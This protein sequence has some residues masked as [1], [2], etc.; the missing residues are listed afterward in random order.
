MPTLLLVRHAIAEPRGAVW[1]DDT[2]RPLTSK[3]IERMHDV[4][5]RLQVLKETADLVLSSPLVRA[6]QTAGIFREVWTPA[7][8]VVLVDA[9]APGG[10]P[11]Q[12]AAALR[13]A[14]GHARVAVVGHEP[15]LGEWAAWLTGARAPLPFKKGGVARIDVPAWPPSR[16]GQL[17]WLATPKMLRGG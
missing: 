9:F 3:G 14:A 8:E 10:T 1:P 4:A 16:D 7:P 6:E 17:V 12:M 11:A 15:D 2:Q 5:A 13:A